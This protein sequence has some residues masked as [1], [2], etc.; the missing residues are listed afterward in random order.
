MFTPILGGDVEK[1]GGI[2]TLGSIVKMG[3]HRY[4]MRL[5]RVDSLI[6]R[7]IGLEKQDLQLENLMF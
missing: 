6:S 3:L 4:H 1:V 2:H 7:G 5:V